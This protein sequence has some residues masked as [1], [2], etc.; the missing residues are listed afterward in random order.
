MQPQIRGFSWDS[1]AF[2]G[3]IAQV[4]QLA[5]VATEGPVGELRGHLYQSFACG[6]GKGEGFNGH[7]EPIEGSFGG[8]GK[9]APGLIARGLSYLTHR[10]PW[11]SAC[12]VAIALP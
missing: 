12:L 3:P 8:V 6:A 9:Y 1:V 7:A 10:R 2:V 11:L 5:P 4:N